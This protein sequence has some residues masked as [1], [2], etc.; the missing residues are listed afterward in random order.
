MKKT[1]EKFKKFIRAN[2]LLL[3]EDSV[4]VGLSGGADSVC[5]LLLLN[6]FKGKL[7]SELSAVHVNH[8]LRGDEALRDQV[9]CQELCLSLGIKIYTINA[10]VKKTAKEKKVSIEE[11]ARI[12]RYE[13]F[14]NLKVEYGVEKI[15]T[16]HNRNDNTETILFNIFRGTGLSGLRGIPIKRD[17]IIRPLLDFTR[18]EIIN[19]LKNNN[20]KYCTDS[21][22][23]SDDYTRNYIRNKIIPDIKL[24]I[25][26]NLEDNVGRLS[27]IYSF[28]EKYLKNRVDETI[29]ASVNHNNGLFKI[30]LPNLKMM[31]DFFLGEF[32]RVF[33]QDI[34]NLEYNHQSFIRIKDL[35][36]GKTGLKINLSGSYWMYRERDSLVVSDEHQIYSDKHLTVVLNSELEFEGK[37][38]I[39]EIVDRPEIV[40]FE[41]NT[42]MLDA[43]NIVPENLKIRYW[44]KADK[45]KP[46][47]LKG[48]KNISDFLQEQK[49]DTFN[50]NRYFIL[51]NGNDII[52]LPGLRIDDRYKITGKTKKI[53]KIRMI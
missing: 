13:I 27:L 41:K 10:D 31:D 23:L 3:K 12:L 21:S 43:E 33:F 19:Y 38:L 49:T 25:N 28:F 5:L 45:F 53:L 1:E 46:L 36:S 15:A 8:M 17:F 11:A 16:A 6:K 7:Y 35:I 48:F 18:D 40:K 24:N 50:K 52:C 2:S 39:F 42:E 47:G 32:F 14:N 26:P 34:I 37:K 22:N 29:S 9:F 30:S 4:L 44:R 51:E 20:Q